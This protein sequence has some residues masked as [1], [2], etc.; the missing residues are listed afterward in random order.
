MEGEVPA[1]ELPGQTDR[2]LNMSNYYEESLA[3]VGLRVSAATSSIWPMGNAL[4]G[5]A[6][7]LK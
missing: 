7:M 4:H 5:D 6:T 1:P 2:A 3:S